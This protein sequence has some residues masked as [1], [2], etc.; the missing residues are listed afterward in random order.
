M[1]PQ[2]FRRHPAESPLKGGHAISTPFGEI[3]PA[4]PC[5]RVGPHRNGPR[6]HEPGLPTTLSDVAAT[7]PGM[8]ILISDDTVRRAAL[9]YGLAD[10]ELRA[11]PRDGAPDGAVF[12]C[13]C[14]DGEVFLKIKPI[15]IGPAAELAR[16]VHVDRLRASGVPV[17]RSVPSRTGAAVEIMSDPAG[18]YAVSVTRRVA[19]RHLQLPADWSDDLVRRWATVLGRMHA[20]AATHDAPAGLPTWRDEHALFLGDC[21]DDELRAVWASFGD[22]LAGLP[23][24]RSCFGP[25]HNDLHLGNLMLAGEELVVLDFD[26]ATTHWFALD[27]AIAL[28]H[29]VWQMRHES[30]GAIAPFVATFLDAYA[31]QHPLPEPWRERLPVFMRYRFTLFV[32]AMERE[33]GH[34]R[35]LPEWLARIRTWVLSGEPLVPA[36]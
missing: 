24:D 1:P 6:T 3:A 2:E 28:A 14:P 4:F 32:L 8:T 22:V 13:P 31:A 27:V 34:P 18:T 33:L 26:V 21:R 23:T 17:P 35:E 36:R 25:V 29:P 10:D 20:V 30:P 15:V 16:A 9:A 11:I 19:G 5:E 12:A 7:V